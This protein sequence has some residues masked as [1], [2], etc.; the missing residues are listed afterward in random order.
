MTIYSVNKNQIRITNDSGSI[1]FIPS[2]SK[3]DPTTAI[4]ASIPQVLAVT[5]SS[6]FNNRLTK[7]T[8]LNAF[9]TITLNSGSVSAESDRRLILRYVDSSS[10]GIIE[11]TDD[12]GLG[13]DG[14]PVTKDLKFSDS[15]SNDTFIDILLN[16]NDDSFL[17]AYKTVAALND[18]PIFNS[19]FSAS[20]VD[21]GSGISAFA[22]KN[23]H[24]GGTGVEGMLVGST[25][26]VRNSASLGT[27]SLTDGGEGIFIITSLN[28]SSVALPDF[29]GTQVQVGGMMVGS[30]FKI[31][32]SP[33]TFKYNIITS[34]SGAKNQ[35]FFEGNVPEVSSSLIQRIDPDD[36][37]SFEFIVPSQSIGG[38]DDLI[39]FYV[40]SSRRIGFATKDPLT[41]IDIRADEFQI[42]RKAERRG[43]RL[44]P[45]G[46]VE[47]FDRNTDTATTGSEFILKYSR[48]ISITK[49]F[50]NAIFGQ[51]FGNDTDAQNFFNALKPD[52][53]QGALKKG[54][55]AGFISPAQAGDTLGQ[56]RWVSESGSIGDFDERVSGEAAS[57][58]AIVSEGAAD[59]V[60]SDLIFSVASKAGTSVQRLAIKANNFH[61]LTGSLKLLN[62]GITLDSSGQ[63]IKLADNEIR[64]KDQPNTRIDI[65]ENQIQ[66]GAQHSA[67]GLKIQQSAITINPTN[68][69][70]Q[71]F[72]VRGDTDDNLIATDAFTNRVGIGTN[73]PDEKLTVDGN[74]KATGNIIA[75]QYIVSSSVTNIT[76]QE[77]SGSTIFGDDATDTHQFTGN[78]TASGKISASGDISTS[79]I[80]VG[81]RIYF[82]N[83]LTNNS[84]GGLN[85][86]ELNFAG[87]DVVRFQPHVKLDSHL[88][89]SGNISASGELLVGGDILIGQTQKISNISQTTTNIQFN[90]NQ[91]LFDSA[92]VEIMR[93]TGAGPTAGV[94]FNAAN[95]STID[96]TFNGHITASGNI[97]ASGEVSANT[98]VVGSTITHIGDSNTKITFDTD[99]I[100]LTVAGKTAIDL[101][102]DG[103]GGG[104]TR[105][106]TFNE[107]HADID[108]RI[109]GD[110]DANLFFTDAGNEKVGIGTGTPGEKLEVIGNISASGKIYSTNVSQFQ[111]SFQGANSATAGEWYGPNTQGPNYYFWNRDYSAYPQVGVSNANSGWHL[112][113]KAY[114][115]SFELKFQNVSNSSHYSVTGALQVLSSDDFSYPITV[116]STI[117]SNVVNYTGQAAYTTGLQHAYTNLSVNVNAT[118]PAGSI[119]YPR[120]NVD[121]GSSNWRGNFIVNYHEVK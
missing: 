36:K 39:P 101:T 5:C 41:D 23:K 31:G 10:K 50:V 56:I 91:I 112:P 11:T 72:F 71:D 82:V 114:I 67:V 111:T 21:D 100:N 8:T 20:L 119:L 108:V 74:I 63:H 120:Y 83:G 26:R 73:T 34:G 79:N 102:Y 53:Q 37:K 115:T 42:Q 96:F 7:L 107:G 16:D 43:I 51:S 87:S 18:S 93:M 48:G 78:I 110:T 77:L 106:I 22:G 103:D 64:H 88:T 80:N 14:Q 76:T 98:I 13:N 12:A 33:D 17:V 81:N 15:L 3:T 55:I 25:F 54:E 89:A 95:D 47:S 97:S 27:T 116:G 70:F 2:G 52:T 1:S 45:E 85:S 75:Q 94:I 86:N 84:I 60:S 49:E 46:N 90:Q 121:L 57:I 44:N 19:S 99:D 62:G 35:P 29:S 69:N 38:T 40:S 58:K 28:S 30:S 4:S 24:I 113:V 92:G 68:V 32:G 117:N 9:G 118:Y 104:D 65:D 61:E 6:N 109:E 66:I 105:E 59:G